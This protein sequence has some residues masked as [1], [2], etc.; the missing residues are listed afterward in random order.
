MFVHISPHVIF[1]TICLYITRSFV[2]RVIDEE[3]Q[4]SNRPPPSII[5]T[6]STFMVHS[7]FFFT[8]LS[9]LLYWTRSYDVTILKLPSSHVRGLLIHSFPCCGFALEQIGRKANGHCLFTNA[10][11]C[12]EMVTISL[13][14]SESWFDDDENRFYSFPRFGNFTA[15]FS[16]VSIFKKYIRYDLFL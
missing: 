4:K 12:W 6:A 3:F 11:S 14:W 15:L 7:P 8:N 16:F 13:Y 1:F 9:S 5:L 10:I 2:S